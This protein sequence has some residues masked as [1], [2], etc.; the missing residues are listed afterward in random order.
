MLRITFIAVLLVG[1]LV[2]GCA[3]TVDAWSCGPL[4]GTW[5]MDTTRSASPVVRP[6]TFTVH[7][8]GTVSDVSGSNIAALGFTARG[9]FLGECAR[10]GPNLYRIMLEELLY[11]D[12][13]VA[14]RFLIELTLQHDPQSDTIAGVSGESRFKITVFTTTPPSPPPAPCIS[15]ANDLLEG[16][17]V[18]EDSNEHEC[19]SAADIELTARRIA[20]DSF[21]SP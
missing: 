10:I 18:R 5:L 11:R 17:M 21:F 8:G 14:G 20:T 7:S 12:G 9:G 16:S 6:V 1:V 19:R 2:S 4:V 3:R 13:L 15:S